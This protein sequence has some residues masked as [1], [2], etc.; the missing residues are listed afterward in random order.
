MDKSYV[1]V[2]CIPIRLLPSLGY[3]VHL[4]MQ[5]FFEQKTPQNMRIIVFFIWRTLLLSLKILSW[6]DTPWG[7]SV[8]LSDKRGVTV[9]KYFVE[10]FKSRYGC[11]GFELVALARQHRPNFKKCLI[12]IGFPPLPS[13]L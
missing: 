12:L 4:V 10:V 13:S 3:I 6:Y 5:D 7:K 9:L 1:P 11:M 2:S 8:N